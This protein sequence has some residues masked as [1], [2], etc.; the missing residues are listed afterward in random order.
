MGIQHT[1]EASEYVFGNGWMPG[2]TRR[3]VIKESDATWNIGRN[4]RAGSI[5]SALGISLSDCVVSD[6]SGMLL[7]DLRPLE[8]HGGGYIVDGYDT[9][10]KFRL[11]ICN[12]LPVAREQAAAAQWSRGER[13]GTLGRLGARPQLRGDK[14]VLEYAGGDPCAD[15]PHHNQS[16]LI[17]FVCDRNAND[18]QGRPVFVAEWAGCAFM[19]EWRTPAACSSTVRADE[20]QGRDTGKFDKDSDASGDTDQPT[21][22]SRGAVAFVAVFVLGSIYILGGFLYNRVLNTSSRLR[23][24]EQLPNYRFWRG[25]YLVGKRVVTAVANGIFYI[26][27]A[28]SGRRG[29]IRIDAAEHNIRNEL[30]HS[31]DE[32][33]EILPI[34]QRS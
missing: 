24:L 27:D 26:G 7:Y 9:G 33:Q 31:D 14:L 19:F 18:G 16:A 12:V 22:A 30:F 4:D 15:L 20:E 34:R 32:D 6:D 11:N 8:H 5:S 2:S 28:V 1:A 29:A 25:I 3:T 21:G 13:N 17:S 23:G 10:Y